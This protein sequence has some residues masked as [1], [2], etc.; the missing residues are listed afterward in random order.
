MTPQDSRDRKTARRINLQ[1]FSLGAGLSS[2]GLSQN[3]CPFLGGSFV[4]ERGFGLWWAS[5]SS[6]VHACGAARKTQSRTKGQA[7]RG[8][9]RRLIGVRLDEGFIQAQ[10]IILLME[11]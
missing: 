7:R 5:V 10:F 9:A 2:R 1:D 3:L 8:L 4:H 11:Y 6:F